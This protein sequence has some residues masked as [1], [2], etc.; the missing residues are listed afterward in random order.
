LLSSG[1]KDAWENAGL[2]CGLSGYSL[3]LQD[4][5]Y[6][7]INSIAG[8]AT[9]SL[10]HQYLVG[11]IFLPPSGGDL[12]VLQAGA[13][14]F[15]ITGDLTI[16]V[17]TNLSEAGSAPHSLI[18]RFL[19]NYDDGGT[20]AQEITEINIS[21][22]LDWQ[23]LTSSVVLQTPQSEH[24]ELQIEAKGYAGDFWFDNYYFNAVSGVFTKDPFCLKIASSFNKPILPNGALIESVYPAD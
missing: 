12:L 15:S 17:K 13:D 16:N 7:L 24:W 3:F 23:T 20:P 14:T 10:L 22:T 8:N 1:E 19:Y 6:R 4:K 21:P 9:P 2:V 11:H 18:A 5:I